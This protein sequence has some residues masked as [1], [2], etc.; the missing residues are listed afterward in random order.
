MERFPSSKQ[1]DEIGYLTGHF[2]RNR[3]R[4]T[5]AVRAFQ[6]SVDRGKTSEYADDAWW[7]LGW[8]Q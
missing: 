6:Q 7:Y 1:A 3:G 5:E 4:V 2:Y 8:L